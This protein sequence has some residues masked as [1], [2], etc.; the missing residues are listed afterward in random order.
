M[1]TTFDR[2]LAGHSPTRH[3]AR[4]KKSDCRIEDLVALLGQTTDLA[5][6]G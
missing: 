5:A 6:C 1:T 2:A 3:P 4:L